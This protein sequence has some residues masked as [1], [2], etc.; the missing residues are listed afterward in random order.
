M[1]VLDMQDKRPLYEQIVERFKELIAR[2]I[3]AADD[4]LP[5]VRQLAIDL[6]INPNTIQRAYGELERNGYIYSVK[7][8]GNFV[9]DISG[10]LNTRQET[11]FS[12]LDEQLRKIDGYSLNPEDVIEHVKNFY[13]EG[14]AK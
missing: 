9:A 1:I 10:M 12:V 13:K 11:Y 8:R 5:S 6:S 7:G 2:E 3:L 4:K 14:M